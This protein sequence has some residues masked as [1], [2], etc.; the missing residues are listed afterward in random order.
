MR[1]ANSAL[2]FFIRF[3]RNEVCSAVAWLLVLL[4]IPMLFPSSG[5]ASA[6]DSRSSFGLTAAESDNTVP[7]SL[8]KSGSGGEDDDDDSGNSGSGS[9]GNNSGSGGGDDDD[10]GE[11]NS[12]SG[13]GGDNNDD[14][15]EDDNSGS[16]SGGDDEEG[17]N[18]GSGNGEDDG[19]E[20]DDNSG[21]GG[22]DDN[23]EGED[24]NSGS[25]SGDDD[26]EED[27]TS[28]PGSGGDERDDRIRREGRDRETIG[29][30]QA[31]LNARWE[32]RDDRTI[33]RVEVRNLILDPPE[34]LTVCAISATTGTVLVEGSLTLN[35][36]GAGEFKID[37]RKGAN[38]PIIEPGDQADVRLGSCASATTPL[39]SARIGGGG[40]VLGDA[41]GDGP[42]DPLPNG[43]RIRREG[44]DRRIISGVQV[45][46]NARWEQRDDRTIFR[47]EIRNLLI[48]S[49]E[50]LN[51]CVL[52]GSDGSL[53]LSGPL[54]LNAFGSGE[55]KLDSRNG[56]EVP[57]VEP[58]D[59]VHV[60]QGGCSSG[61]S[62]ILSATIGGGVSTIP[63]EGDRIR[64][65]GRDRE[66]VDGVEVELNARWER[67]DD[68]TTFRVEVERFLA[69]QGET[70]SVCLISGA[71]GN[72][73]LEGQVALNSLGTG[74]F[75]V[76]SRNG[77]AVP[78]AEP[79][80]IVNVQTE[81]CS[82]GASAL[83]SATIGSGAISDSSPAASCGLEV[84]E[85]HGSDDTEFFVAASGAH[86]EDG[87]LD[88]TIELFAIDSENNDVLVTLLEVRDK[89]RLRSGRDR[90]EV[91]L[92][93]GGELVDNEFE[94]RAEAPSF[95]LSCTVSDSEG[96]V[97]VDDVS[98]APG[99]STTVR[100]NRNGVLNAATFGPAGSVDEAVAPGS[101]IS[102]FGEFGVGPS[103]AQQVPLP[104]ELND[105]SVT[106][107]G[108][109][110]PLFFVSARQINAQ[111]PWSAL[112]AGQT[113]GL[114]SVQVTA[115]GLAGLPRTV[116]IRDFAPGIFTLQAGTGPAVAMN[117]DGTLAQPRHS[118]PGI[119]SRPAR[120]GEVLVILATGLGPAAQ[121]IQAGEAAGDEIIRTEATPDVLIG[122]L[123]AQIVFSGL[124]PEFV[125]VN[126][127]NV[128]TPNVDGGQ[129]VSLQIR[130][131]STLT[132]DEVT[133]AVE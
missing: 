117:L 89:L 76:D 44:R 43:S 33:F 72:V 81:A 11:E 5:A 18:S 56:D 108:V 88:P 99:V 39:L 20:E 65:E 80:D 17:D 16:G 84:A 101:I 90:I 51:V 124:S 29:G 61:D 7:S 23:G 59:I 75:K 119:N 22:G 78:V 83:L 28:G 102:L 47:A 46:L 100:L 123:K 4:S 62:P 86:A 97:G 115:N 21:P 58:G 38:V 113:A 96:M 67:R 31:E 64:R 116:R 12:G 45:E 54:A 48:D 8:A 2:N 85:T 133:I 50:P 118:V 42:G 1:R 40:G 24:D 49:A 77:D 63:R 98:V 37:S 52:D 41:P 122:G 112:K 128:I 35:S 94:V 3:T 69:H 125:G 6:A 92:A 57:P 9:G 53:I 71:S 26:D 132:R 68:R 87:S 110:V 121:S 93:D 36:F 60:Q 130:L 15:G 91:E 73:V 126:Q 14:D 13:S 19:E 30:V 127:L 27:D 129:E 70:L 55:F 74:E 32:Q 66:I 120:A 109:P 25:G 95:R 131:G 103:Q 106:I 105:L 114:A 34:T 107:N 111:L 82:S 79:G 10:D 104:S